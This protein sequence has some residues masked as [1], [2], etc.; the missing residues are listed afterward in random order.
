M[1]RPGS[2]IVSGPALTVGDAAGLVDPLSGEGIG[3]AIQSAGLA[4]RA[5]EAYL[6]ERAADLSP[7]QTAVDELIM[8]ELIAS[9]TLQDIFHYAPAPY[10]FALQHSPLFWRFMCRIIRGE[11]TYTGFLEMLGPL[12]LLVDAWDVVAR[13]SRYPRG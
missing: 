4:A 11:V 6:A 12:R 10:T 8:P 1:R 9:R 7:Y 2:P 3:T 5:I 13:R